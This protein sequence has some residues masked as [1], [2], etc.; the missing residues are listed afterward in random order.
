MLQALPFT[1]V[2]HTRRV[3]I[4]FGGTAKRD[5]G[6]FGRIDAGYASIEAQTS[7]GSLHAHSQLCLRCLHQRTSVR[8][9][10]HVARTDGHEFVKG[11][12]EYNALVRRQVYMTPEEQVHA[13]LLECEQQWPVS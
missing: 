6:I 2:L 10:L 13:V 9:I 1:A 5:G 8:D 3:N 7:S 12:L 4:L 11:Y